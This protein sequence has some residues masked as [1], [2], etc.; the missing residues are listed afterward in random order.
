METSPPA[1]TA[2]RPSLA[3]TL[4][5]LAA[6]LVVAIIF[7]ASSSWYLAWKTIHVLF[8]VIWIGGGFILIT[9]GLIADQRG[10]A[11]GKTTIARQAGQVAMKVFTP[12]ALIVL[13]AGIAMMLTDVGELAWDWGSFWVTFGLLGFVATFA[14]GIGVLTPA[15]KKIEALAETKGPE[16]PETQEALSRLLL[17]ARVDS[18]VLLLVIVDMVAKP[19]LT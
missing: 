7:L 11:V 19:F 16:A 3:P 5:V 6:F 12:S 4:L 1:S 2:A 8:A 17:I 18:A 10:D 13:V 14:I 9:L 15:A